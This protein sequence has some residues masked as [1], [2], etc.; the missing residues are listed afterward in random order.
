[1][2]LFRRKERKP[3]DME[4]IF[5]EAHAEV[6]ARR[7]KNKVIEAEVLQ[8]IGEATNPLADKALSLVDALPESERSIFLQ[9]VFQRLVLQTINS[10]AEGV[11]GDQINNHFAK[12]ADRF[13]G[14]VVMHYG[15]GMPSWGNAPLES[16]VIEESRPL[17][18]QPVLKLQ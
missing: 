2:G 18:E 4:Q 10:T 5:A 13:G 11:K 8:T 14:Q 15:D 6:A 1:M 17:Y 7:A 3:F 12:E 16:V 9:R